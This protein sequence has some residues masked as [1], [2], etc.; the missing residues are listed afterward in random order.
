LIVDG[1]YDEVVA[2]LHDP[3]DFAVEGRVAA[4]VVAG[5]L[6][7]DED[8]RGVVDGAEVDEEVGVR[9]GVDREVAL[10]PEQ[11]FVVCEFQSPGTSRVGERAKSYCTSG[12]PGR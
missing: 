4:F 10:I 1:D 3:G 12:P 8:G 6:A 5:E 7:V 9:F 11:A 2:V